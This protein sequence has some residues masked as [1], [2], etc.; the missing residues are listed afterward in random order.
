MTTTPSHHDPDA[1][2]AAAAE[3]VVRCGYWGA[4]RNLWTN[5][6]LILPVMGL[7][8][9]ALMISRPGMNNAVNSALKWPFHLLGREGVVA[10]NFVLLAAFFWAGCRHE[11]EDAQ[12]GGRL[13]AIMLAESVCWGLLMSLVTLLPLRALWPNSLSPPIEERESVGVMLSVGAGLYEELIFRCLL[14]GSIYA[15]LTRRRGWTGPRETAAVLLALLVSS[16]VFSYMHYVG[17]CGDP[18][19]LPSFLFRFGAGMALGVLYFTRGLGVAVYAHA[20][21][22]VLLVLGLA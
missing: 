6:L 9:L 19:T 13:F 16:A 22:D 17:P 10:F 4:T 12:A 21:Y 2:L 8:E 14:A 5:L 20:T 3:G 11:D 1:S 18:L 15:Y 7:Y